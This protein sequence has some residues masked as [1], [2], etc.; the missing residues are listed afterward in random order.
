MSKQVP[1][2]VAE[3]E[4][5][6]GIPTAPWNLSGSAC[7]TLWRLPETELPYPGAEIAYASLGGKALLITAWADYLGEGTLNYRELA[8]GAVIRGKGLLSPSCTATHVWVDDQSARDGGRQLWGIPKQLGTFTSQSSDA[9]RSF[10]ARLDTTE[11][12]VASVSFEA[13]MALPGSQ[14]L[15]GFIVQPGE[16]G[17]RRTRCTGRGRLVTGRATWVFDE[18]GPLAF[19]RGAKP[20]F[21]L[22]AL[23]LQGWFGI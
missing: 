8:V 6:D 11:H 5:D 19:M 17:P 15:T 13:T 1:R 2:S 3:P 18:Q 14:T 12:P 21:S 22:R 7:V 16:G 20:L 23:R 10:A 4:F 9:E